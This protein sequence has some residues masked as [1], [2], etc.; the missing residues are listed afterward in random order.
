MLTGLGGVR[1]YFRRRNTRDSVGLLVSE[2][3]M[4]AEAVENNESFLKMVLHS[5]LWLPEKPSG[6][7]S[8]EQEPLQE[9]SFF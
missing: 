4:P 6:H 9:F 5:S 7:W 8:P 2:W 1:S 3:M